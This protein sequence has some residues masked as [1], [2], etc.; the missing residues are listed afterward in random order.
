MK[1]LDKDTVKFKLNQIG[2]GKEFVVIFYKASTGEQRKMRCMMEPPT[3]EP[4]NPNVVPVMDLDK[5]A[6]RSFKVDSVAF[7]GE[8]Q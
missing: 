4:K 6:W 5:G 2:Y 3:G 8:V 1:T 7:L